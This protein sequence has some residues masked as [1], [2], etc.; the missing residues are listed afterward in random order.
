MAVANSSTVVTTASGSVR[1]RILRG[2]RQ[3]TGIPYAE[4]PIGP[5]RFKAPL[6]AKPWPGELDATQPAA[7]PP[8]DADPAMPP[9]VP[10]AED[11]L[12]LNVWAPL[13]P[14]SYPVLVWI[15]G[16]GNSSGASNQPPYQGERFARDGVVCVSINYRVGVLGFLELGTVP[17]ASDAG[18]G[19]N[20]LRDQVLALQ[21]IR[22]NIAAFGGD[23]QNVTIAGQSAGAWN[24]A[25]LLVLPAAKGLFHRAILASG[26]ADA[27]YSLERAA[28]FGSRFVAR[29]GGAH[30]LYEASVQEILAA[31]HAT[32]AEFP[33]PLP[34]LPVVD[35]KFLP[36]EPLALLRT[37]VASAVTTMVGHTHDEARYIFDA[38]HADSPVARKMLRHVSAAVLP[39]IMDR[40]QRAFPDLSP[41]ERMLRILSADLV[42]IPTLRIAEAQVGSGATVY[43]YHLRY[44]VAHGPFGSYS[45]HGID[46]PL[47]FEHVDTA[48]ARNVFGY[49]AGDLPMAQRV[50]TAWVSFIQSGKVTA[51]LPHWPAYDLSRRRVMTIVGPDPG[52]VDDPERVERDIW[53]GIA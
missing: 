44:A 21:W 4:P 36:A 32:Q 47:I 24:C 13:S 53:A 2:V 38:A 45:P 27:V 14:G 9:V 12:Q 18:S 1:G 42:G 39:T 31:Q 37:G 25:T 5:L 49:S 34:F 40:Y 48:F 11:C 3:F 46:V 30:R 52:V 50:H 22:D 19:N 33:E 15:Y 16:G 6:P 17:G 8:Q 20:A 41:G 43:Y 23:P 29:L 28:D 35:G 26:A 10:I 7:T 51:G